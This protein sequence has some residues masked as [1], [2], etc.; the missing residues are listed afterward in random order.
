MTRVQL[1][2]IENRIQVRGPVAVR[3]TFP[4]ETL[5]ILTSVINLQFKLL[6]L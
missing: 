3:E 6:Q 5:N 4:R 2:G 1:V